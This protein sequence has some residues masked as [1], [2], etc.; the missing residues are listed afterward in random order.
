MKIPIVMHM[1]TPPTYEH[2]DTCTPTHT[3]ATT[4]TTTQTFQTKQS[5]LN[6][7]LESS[8]MGERLHWSFWLAHQRLALH[9]CSMQ[10]ED[11]WLSSIP[12]D[13]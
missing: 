12:S 6:T 10:D 8:F 5:A 11:L 9:R 4:T 1:H 3:N 13:F 7:K 2:T